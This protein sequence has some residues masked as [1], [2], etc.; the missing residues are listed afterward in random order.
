MAGSPIEIQ[1]I[2][3]L[4]D[5]LRLPALDSATRAEREA[6]LEVARASYDAA[7][8]DAD[9]LI[10]FGRR[11]AYLGQY[12]EAIAV[13]T[14]GA[15]QFPE[16]ARMFRHRGHRFITVRMLDSALTD[17]L[18]ATQ[19][20]AN[21]PD[22]PEPDGLPNARGVPTS[23]L[24]SNIWYHLGLVHYLRGDFQRA[25]SAYRE[26][27]KYADNPDMRVATSHWLY[28]SL[29]R[30]GAD[31]E[32]AAVLGDITPDMDIIENQAYHRLLLSYQGAIAPAVLLE[33]ARRGDALGNAT[34]G[35]GVANWYV[36]TGEAGR[37]D[38]VFA[39]ILAGPEWAAFGYIAAEADVARRR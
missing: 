20:S 7:P 27:L 16:D 19:L 29:R 26:C 38:S 17:L 24:N 36:Y 31:A 6:Q 35:Y 28:M 1:A 2:S 21:R 14:R 34:L 33:E 11:L 32:A 8:D 15:E 25:A 22:E 30:L 10:W 37:A 13:F 9:A 39:D 12:R 18:R 23:T 3:L 5:S 4:G